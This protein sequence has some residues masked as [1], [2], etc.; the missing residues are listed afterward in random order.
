MALQFKIEGLYGREA[1]VEMRKTKNKE[2]P[3]LD[4][5]VQLYDKILPTWEQIPIDWKL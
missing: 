3:I 1:L 5:L 2:K 4:E